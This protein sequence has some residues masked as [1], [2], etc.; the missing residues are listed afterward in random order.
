M[1]DKKI[2]LEKS[3]IFDEAFG[4]LSEAIL[5]NHKKNP[6]NRTKQL[7]RDL[8]NIRGYVAEVEGDLYITY[9]LIEKY[10]N[11]LR[12]ENKKNQVL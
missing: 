10:R 11:E 4:R 9:E 8:I 6:N 5:A 1:I 3:I 12:R 2:K 7:M